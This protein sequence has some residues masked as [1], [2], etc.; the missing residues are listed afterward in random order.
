MR[1]RHRLHVAGFRDAC[2]LIRTAQLSIRVQLT[3]LSD[4]SALT[5][6]TAAQAA[7]QND[8]EFLVAYGYRIKKYYYLAGIAGDRKSVV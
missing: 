4:S 2:A 6:G 1:V 8:S 7:L 3:F 5:S